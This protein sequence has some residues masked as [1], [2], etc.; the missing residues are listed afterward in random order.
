MK[1]C[2]LDASVAVKWYLDEPGSEAARALQ[3]F[4]VGL[5]A[6]QFLLVEVANILWKYSRKGELSPTT[7]SR[8][9]H[10]L[11]GAPIEWQEDSHLYQDAFQLA[12]ETGRTAYDCLYLSLAITT[13]RPF[14]TADRKLY[15]ALQGTPLE[16]HLVWV[17]DIP[18]WISHSTS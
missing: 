15:N 2:V 10:H 6:P 17:D 11:G 5:I 12:T 3:G 16:R 13:D 7:G 9:L 18:R 8:I 14:V 1:G 4:T